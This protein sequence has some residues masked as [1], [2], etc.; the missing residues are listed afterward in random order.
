[1]IERAR[2][3]PALRSSLW[4]AEWGQASTNSI[5]ASLQTSAC[6]EE[7]RIGLAMGLFEQRLHTY[8]KVLYLFL[9]ERPLLRVTDHLIMLGIDYGSPLNL[10]EPNASRL[11][12][13]LLERAQSRNRWYYF[14]TPEWTLRPISEFP[15]TSDLPTASTKKLGDLAS[16]EGASLCIQHHPYLFAA[17]D[18]IEAH[19]TPVRREDLKERFNL[20]TGQLDLLMAELRQLGTPNLA[21]PHRMKGRKDSH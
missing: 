16:W 2:N 21:P 11:C 12:Q 9:D 5:A 8:R 14:F 3:A 6:T 17:L 1:L 7:L 15:P 4:G 18:F 19:P 13:A 10:E 20:G